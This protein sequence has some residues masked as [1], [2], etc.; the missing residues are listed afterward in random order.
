MQKFLLFISIILALVSCK[1]NSNPSNE[2]IDQQSVKTDWVWDS[3]Q[4][5]PVQAEQHY[6][7]IAPTL[8]QGF[9]YANKRADRTLQLIGSAL[10]FIL[11]V[12]VFAAR[13]FDPTASKTPKFLLNSYIFHG[14]AFLLISF[15]LYFYLGFPLGVRWNNDKWVKKEVYEK[16]M[17]TT[18]STKPIWDSLESNCLIIDGPYGCYKK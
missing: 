17:Q 3:V 6:Y 1:G 4:N 7:L 14:L 8:Q 9:Y 10:L 5:K 2:I 13:I 18:G 11:F 12:L 15:S 16:A